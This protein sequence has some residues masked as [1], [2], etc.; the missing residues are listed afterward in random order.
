M[1]APEIGIFA[2]YEDGYADNEYKSEEM[3]GVSLVMR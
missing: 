3:R 1:D 2:K